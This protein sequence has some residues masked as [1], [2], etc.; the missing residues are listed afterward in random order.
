MNLK[1]KDRILKSAKELISEKGLQQASVREIS[2]LA[3]VTTGSIYHHYKNKE[4]ILYEVMDTS[5]SE[6][7][8]IL[9]EYIHDKTVNCETMNSDIL[10]N[11]LKSFIDRFEKDS[12]NKIQL[13]LTVL[14]IEGNEEIKNKMIV[15]YNTWIIDVAQL[16]TLT[17]KDMT[18]SKVNALSCVLLATIDGLILQNLIG[19]DIA[20]NDDILEIYTLL[21][22]KAIPEVINSVK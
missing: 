9:E 19:V 6:S 20:N 5:L 1:G 11:V 10:D 12:E 21:L 4:E 2:K 8:K 13:Y 22:K 14:G 7:H 18:I 17:Y 15:K 16:L 3:G